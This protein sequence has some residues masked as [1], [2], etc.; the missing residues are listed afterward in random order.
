MKIIQAGEI[1]IIFFALGFVEFN[2]QIMFW[3][4][5][6]KPICFLKVDSFYHTEGAKLS[7]PEA[8]AQIHI[9]RFKK[10]KKKAFGTHNVNN[11][12]WRINI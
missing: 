10:K 2:I 6:V 8:I 11:E 3:S 9:M 12:L 7:I 4:Q 5:R 1:L